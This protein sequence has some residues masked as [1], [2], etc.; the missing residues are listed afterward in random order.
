[1]GGDGRKSLNYSRIKMKMG[2]KGCETNKQI[3]VYIQEQ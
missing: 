1:M 3:D 2:R